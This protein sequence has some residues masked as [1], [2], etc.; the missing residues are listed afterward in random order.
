[1]SKS[2][3]S[4]SP[5]VRK[6]RTQKTV[7]NGHPT[8]EEIALRAY[9]IYLSR[10]GE[11]GNAFEDWARAERE[12]IEESKAKSRKSKFET[13]AAYAAAGTSRPS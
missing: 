4:S 11:P 3:E 9:H 13:P 6:P 2:R 12:L 8:Q 1:M 5:K 10:R 7:A